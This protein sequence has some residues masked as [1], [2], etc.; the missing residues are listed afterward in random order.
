MI[1]YM[2]MYI[3]NTPLFKN[4]YDDLS[5]IRSRAKIY[6]SHSKIDITLYTLASYAAYPWSNIL[7]K[8]ELEDKSKY[9]FFEKEVKK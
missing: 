9:D 8:Y 2:D 6:R 5:K 7:I 1:L 3:T 4:L